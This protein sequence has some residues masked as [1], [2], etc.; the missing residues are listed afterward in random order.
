MTS[1]VDDSGL[2]RFASL[3]RAWRE[4]SRARQ[5][6]ALAAF[7]LQRLGGTV[8]ALTSAL[9]QQNKAYGRA[10]ATIGQLR[11]QLARYS[12]YRD[13]IVWYRRRNIRLRA[14]L[15]SSLD[16]LQ[17]DVQQALTDRDP[18]DHAESALIAR[19][20]F[21]TFLKARTDD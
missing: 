2:T 5:D 4:W 11:A 18:L 16:S 13:S 21:E 20:V 10:S 19:T 1:G 14:E 3:P 17:L 8:E 9:R 7:E 12:G 15:L 6:L